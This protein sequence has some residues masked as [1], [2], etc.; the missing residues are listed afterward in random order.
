MTKDDVNL[1]TISLLNI[2]YI[3]PQKIDI[4]INLI[5]EK[6][7][8][9]VYKRFNRELF[10]DTKN[11][12]FKNIYMNKDENNN[13]FERIINNK[14][15]AEKTL[16]LNK[17][18]NSSQNLINRNYFDINN[19]NI[20]EIKSSKNTNLMN[21]INDTFENTNVPNSKD[22]KNNNNNSDTKNN[23]NRQL[24]LNHSLVVVNLLVL[25]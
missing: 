16:S 10:M 8:C 7:Q 1:F 12:N 20:I 15:I 2:Q 22:D 3:F 11:D 6:L 14:T 13:N 17:N 4:K 9:Q 18:V 24:L 23:R 5:D 25:I 21:K 19:K